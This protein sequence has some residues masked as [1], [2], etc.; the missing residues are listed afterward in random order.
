M[1]EKYQILDNEGNDLIKIRLNEYA[2]VVKWAWDNLYKW[3]L[4]KTKVD[5]TN[6]TPSKR[7]TAFIF[8]RIEK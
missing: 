6:D 3:E 5:Y 2:Q 4:V 1:E 8:K 7:V